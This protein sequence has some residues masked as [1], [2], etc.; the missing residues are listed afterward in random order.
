MAFG[1]AGLYIAQWPSLF[2]L[3]ADFARSVTSGF[4]LSNMIGSTNR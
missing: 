3:R 1:D 2:L 4:R